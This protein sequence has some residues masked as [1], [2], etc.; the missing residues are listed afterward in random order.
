MD[1]GASCLSD[2][3]VSSFLERSLSSE[4]R[5][6]LEAHVDGCASCR[7]LLVALSAVLPMS[8]TSAAL[9]TTLP[10]RGLTG[11]ASPLLRGTVVGRFVVLDLLGAG[12]MGVVYTA[13]DPEL[14]RDIALK[15]LGPRVK[16]M[17]HAR[18]H[19][20]AEAQAM[21]RI[22]HANVIAVYDVGTFRDQVFV[23]ME[24]VEGFTLRTWMTD[25]LHTWRDVVDL[26]LRAGEGLAAA[27]A[28]GVVHRD[29]KPENVLLG[30]DGRVK[31]SDF[32]LANQPSATTT[33]IVGTPGY[34]PVEAFRPGGS[35]ERGDQFSFCVALHEALH[36]SRPFS[37]RGFDELV[38]EIRRGPSLDGADRRVPARLN[39]VVRRGLALEPSDRY[40]SMRE[41][42]IE[43]RRAATR[44][45]TRQ[46]TAATIAGLALVS[47]AA[48]VISL[49]NGATPAPC[50]GAAA[51]LAGI[52]DPTGRAAVKSA[53]LRAATPAAAAAFAAASTQLDRYAAD[54][55]AIRTDACEATEVRHT[56][57]AAMLDLRM[58]CL[59]RAR[60]QLRA[61]V[62]DLANADADTVRQAVSAV[63][64]LPALDACS[65]PD[66]LHAIISPLLGA[67]ARS[68]LPSPGDA[69]DAPPK[70][71]LGDRTGRPDFR[72]PFG[73]GEAW[74]LIARSR[75]AR[76]DR[77]ID[78]ILP[79][80]E[81][82]AGLA[83]FASAPGWVSN[84]L[85]EN[86]EVDL[87][88]GGGWSTTYQHMTEITVAPRQYVGR[89]H[90]IGKVAS[91]NVTNSLGGRGAAHLHYE[92][93]YQPD[94]AAVSFDREREPGRQVPF[95]EGEAFRLSVTGTQIRTSSNNCFAGGVPGG[96][97]AYDVPSSTTVFSPSRGTTEI[98][99]RRSDDHVLFEHWYDLGWS[100]APLPHTIVGRPAVAVYQGAL[101]V[102]A[103]KSDGAIFDLEYSPFRG[104]TTTNLDGHVSGDPDVGLHG[105]NN[106]LYV[107][108]RGSDGFLY[109]WWM[110]NGSWAHG[111]RVGNTQVIGTPALF[112]H[113]DT[114][115]IVARS[116]D[117][118][119]RSWETDRRRGWAESQPL[120]ATSDDPAISVDPQA[121]LVNI[122]AR[123]T[124]DRIYR[125]QSPGPARALQRAG[126]GWSARELVD[127]HRFAIGAP[128]AA[129]YHRVLHIIAR[130]PNNA[131]YHWWKDTSW[132]GDVLPGAY[133]S[134]PDIFESGDTLQ[135][136]GRGT[137]GNLHAIW[138]D[139][140]AGRWTGETH[141][142]PVSD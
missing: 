121:G 131:V 63:A 17:S 4:R 35:D 103:R 25:P 15:V 133:S 66:A 14:A 113:Y 48:L 45:R 109:Q 111:V 2:S 140:L 83:V 29:F 104:W 138:Y 97:T 96:A 50:A 79:G 110:E 128:A 92:Q 61:L 57:P 89:G 37:A 80:D 72:L 42:L 6:E 126:A 122:V 75:S 20:L 43:L 36:G 28:A 51:Q 107:A 142:V 38:A 135:T 47:G 141:D 3:T 11:G 24:L 101:H 5:A 120:G 41:L 98:M 137:D 130:G 86:G 76:G 90:V 52:W 94:V 125:W 82:A 27:H 59:D 33:G 40:A 30:S 19:L 32:G 139:P 74:Q 136:I 23:A 106:R 116:I 123:G 91:V 119:L 9:H 115:Y 129:I 56:Q 58:A 13:H 65:D 7:Q 95:L 84:V 124:D 46:R 16:D 71:D 81:G 118:T 88:H 21:A 49:Q 67:A 44:R 112:S 8:S 85:P 39:R 64:A 34:L 31:V 102:I 114:F 68:Q 26:F 54:W 53:F 10:A 22:S 12:G 134:N 69:V 100:S 93:V 18:A 117:G 73:C 77:G 1:C 132:H 55:A 87:N 78:F 70:T 127:D 99:I 105:W 60:I 62:G 108:A